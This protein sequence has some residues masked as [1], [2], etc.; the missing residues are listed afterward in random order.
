MPE[1]RRD[2]LVVQLVGEK[3]DQAVVMF[4]NGAFLKFH[5]MQL[6]VIEPK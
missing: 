3:Q 2:G 5:V 4:S 6:K 1:G